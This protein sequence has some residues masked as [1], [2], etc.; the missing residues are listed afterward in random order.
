MYIVTT[1]SYDELSRLIRDKKIS[2]NNADLLFGYTTDGINKYFS[3]RIGNTGY[4]V[5]L[6]GRINPTTAQVF[7]QLDKAVKSGDRV[8]L[9]AEINEDDMISFT[10][11]GI[12]AAAEALAYGLPDED[13]YNQLDH[14]QLSGQPGEDKIQVICI[15]HI[16]LENKLRVTSLR[17]EIAFNLKGITFV[18]L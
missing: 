13:I 2:L 8:I 6:R 17:E 15:P 12:N 14:S 1:L 3:E 4:V 5:G 10:V 7:A 11:D 18:K 16:K 9:E